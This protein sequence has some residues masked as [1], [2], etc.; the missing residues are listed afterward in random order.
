MSALVRALKPFH[1]SLRGAP[2]GLPFI[3]D[4]R[5]LRNGLNFTFDT[6]IGPIDLLGDAG[7]IFF[8]DLWAHAT[9]F[10]VNELPVYLASIDD[11]LIMKRAANREKDKI[12]IKEL[13]ALKKLKEAEGL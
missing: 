12:H 8:D 7:G 3:F 1:V 11:L 4:E 2:E 6:D 5:S 9:P 10:S 13:E